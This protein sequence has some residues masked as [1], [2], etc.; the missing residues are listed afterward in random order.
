MLGNWQ[1]WCRLCAKIGS[2][3]TEELHKMESLREHLEIVSKHFMISIQPLQENSNI[4]SECRG[5]L[6]KLDEFK[7]QCLKADKMFEELIQNHSESDLDL[8]LIRIKYGFDAEDTKYAGNLFQVPKEE[9]SQE[10]SVMEGENYDPLETEL[11][12]KETD[13]E[14]GVKEE[15]PVEQVHKKRGRPKKSISGSTGAKGRKVRI[16]KKS[17]NNLAD[18]KSIDKEELKRRQKRIWN[19]TGKKDHKCSF[20]PKGFSRPNVLQDHILAKHRKEEMTHVCAQCDRRFVS[21]YRLKLHETVHLPD[22][23]RQVF[24]CAYCDKKFTH[25]NSV[26]LHVTAKHL[27]EKFFTCEECGK[28]F[29]TKSSLTEHQT[30]HS[31]ARPYQCSDC[32]K[33][34]KKR[35]HLKMHEEGHKSNMFQCPHCDL[36]LRTSRTLKMHMLVHSDHKQY[37]CNY[38]GNEYKRAKTLK[39]HLILHTGQRPYECPFCDKT[40]A[41]GSN[42]RSHKKKAHPVQ[43]A[44]LEASLQPGATLNLSKLDELKAK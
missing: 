21:S 28:S 20:C 5:F 16:R 32:L 31:E 24:P 6:R 9:V 39:E 44:A 36:K 15:I 26:D 37:K 35:Q 38:C 13:E 14:I 41:N 42:C 1:N 17:D 3:S 4:C 19:G 34:F 25:K 27:C 10:N 12:M 8:E 2:T 7:D 29:T 33:R 18:D 11:K 43:L 23:D 40:F 22:A 30:S